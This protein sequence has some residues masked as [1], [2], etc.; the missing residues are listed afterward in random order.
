MI[1]TFL[2]LTNPVRKASH[3]LANLLNPPRKRQLMVAFM[4][5]LFALLSWARLTRARGWHYHPGTASLPGART[6]PRSHPMIQLEIRYHRVQVNITDQVAVTHVDQVFYN[7][8][9][10]DVE[11]TYIF[12][13]PIGAAV[14]FLHPVGGWR[15]SRG[16]ST[17]CGPGQA[18]LP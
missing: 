10:W 11:G 12:P 2:S 1:N 4:A 14:Y 18:D 3:I 5:S 8:N 15:A 17:G 6:L 9:D 16:E 7:P 13:I